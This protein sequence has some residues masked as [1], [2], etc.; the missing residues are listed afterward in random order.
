MGLKKI[1]FLIEIIIC[2]IL[3][4]IIMIFFKND[5]LTLTLK[6]YGVIC[7]IHFF[8]CYLLFYRISKKM[9][10]LYSCFLFAYFSFQCGQYILYGFGLKYNYVYLEHY[11]TSIVIESVKY[12]LLCNGAAVL[13]GIYSLSKSRPN[14][15][16]KIDYY[17][18]Q[19]ILRISKIIWILLS[20][21]EIPY[22]IIRFKIALQ[23]GYHGVIKYEG[24]LPS[25]LSLIDMLYVPICILMVL[26]SKNKTKKY[27][28]TYI[29]LFISI[30]NA[31]NGDRSL[32]IGGI[33]IFSL[34]YLN[35]LL[36]NNIKNREKNKKKNYI[37]FTV[38][39]ILA[40][41][42]IMFAYKF[43][44]QEKEIK[45]FDS[46]FSNI[47]NVIGEL[48]FSFFPLVLTMRIC[49]SEENYLYGKSIFFSFLASFIP[50]SIDITGL[51]KY[52]YFLSKEGYFWI[53]EYYNYTFGLG[54]SLNA[55][56]YSNFGMLGF[57]WNFVLCIIVAYFLA[58]PNFEEENTKFS[59]YTGLSL[60][61]IWFTMPRRS[62]YYIG[63]FI[64]YYIILTGLI[65]IIFS[66][67]Y[68]LYKKGDRI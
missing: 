64:F 57:I 54:Y 14:F 65:F 58:E 4:Y 31:L 3:F 21:I 38:I 41:Y 60:L 63:N 32:G 48:G 61:Y 23:Y 18:P 45:F 30:L 40:S 52:F 68:K 43:R 34:I 53:E 17:N 28:Y 27:F 66:K 42:L 50:Q 11:E 55:E 19:N 7:F 62:S 25:F 10:T 16:K 33:I 44:T 35:G 26:Y 51:S 9:I 47:V 2:T 24:S 67:K 5:N 6:I 20:G 37:I 46:V 49:P 8:I 56:S 29:I 12:S 15:I 39:S 36:E 59:Q 22:L 13:A 1:Y